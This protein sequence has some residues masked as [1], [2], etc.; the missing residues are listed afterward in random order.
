[1]K[2]RR[3][4]RWKATKMRPTRNPRR[5]AKPRPKRPVCDTES[6]DNAPT[7]P[8]V[9]AILES[10]P[11]TP[12]ELLRAI[13][14]LVDLGHANLAKEFVDELGQRKLDVPAKAALVKAFNPATLLKL[15]RDKEL[16]AVLAPLI[17]DWLAAAEAYRRDPARL[18][19]AAKQLGDPNEAIRAQATLALVQA[20][21]AAVAPLVALSGRSEANREHGVAKEV[22]VYL[23]DLAVAPLL[24]V[25]ESPD[26]ALKTQVIEV[27]GRMRTPEAVPQLLAA[28]VG[29][30]GPTTMQAAAGRAWRK[31]RVACRARATRWSCW[32]KRRAEPLD[33]SRNESADSAVPDGGLA[34]ELEEAR[35]HA[36]R[37]RRDRGG[38]GQGCRGWLATLHLV[39]PANA[40]RRRLYLTAMLQAAKFRGGLD[41]P[42]PAGDGTA[43]A[44]AAYYGPDMFDDVLADA[45]AD[46]YIPA[47]TAA[48]QILGRHRQR[49][50]AGARWRRPQPAGPRGRNTPIAGCGSRR[51]MRS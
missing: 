15:A 18:A 45:M 19:A 21:E 14:I 32:N 30:A 25:L 3:P 11:K 8:A 23:G 41:K 43:Y 12:A 16:G 5:P 46:G 47:A 2:Q 39:D 1:M 44:V 4:T 51:S 31:S 40:A 34:L 17:D 20:R 13:N 29:P 37:V 7:D 48:A 35:E 28:L 9:L 27:L 6:G 36:D 26:A 38:A 24:G 33:Q 22:L 50:A 42:L 49:R 10:H